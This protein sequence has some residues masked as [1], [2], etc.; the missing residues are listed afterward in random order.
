MAEMS[1]QEIQD[2]LFSLSAKKSSDE[3]PETLN[4]SAGTDPQTIK[5]IQDLKD[6][7]LIVWDFNMKSQ[8]WMTPVSNPAGMIKCIAYYGNAVNGYY[9]VGYALGCINKEATA[10][11][12]NFIEKR[13]DA[14]VDLCSKF[15]PVIVD[16]VSTYALYLNS[17]EAAK[18]SKFV[19]VGPVPGVRQYYQEQGFEY[20]EGYLGSH[21]MVK[22]LVK[23]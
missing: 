6:K 22:Y 9:C 1:Q 16:A 23:F 8:L 18:I 12:I 19:L 21:A 2:A 10:V 4:L 7:G 20:I 5:D 13:R 11:E 17:I 3:L 14:S 15:L